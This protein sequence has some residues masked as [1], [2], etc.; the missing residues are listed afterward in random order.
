MSLHVS[1][2]LLEKYRTSAPRYT[3]YPTAID[4][5]PESFEPANYADELKAAA[6]N[7]APISVYVHVPFCEQMCLFC[8]CNVVITRSTDRVDRYLDRLECEFE[9]VG[10]TGIGSRPVHQ[11]HWGGGTPTHLTP[12]RML[13]LQ[14]AFDDVFTRTEDSESAIEV[15]PRV[16]TLEHLDALAQ[17]GFGRISMGV[18]DFEEDVQVAINRVQSIEQTRMLVDGAR[19]RGMQSVNIDLMYGLPHQTLEGFQRTI[20]VVL[21]MRPERVALFHYA[22]VPWMKKHQ[23]AL[24]MGVAPSSEIKLE[25]FLRAME[26]F[27]QAGY[28]Y[29]GLDHFA[30]PDDELARAAKAERLHRNF[31]GYTTHKG[32][33]MVS[34]GVSAIG[35]VNGCFAQ[36]F[37]SDAEYLDAID[38][39]GLATKRGHRMSDDDRLRRDI[40]MGIMCNGVLDT[41][42]IGADH[43]V[44]VNTMFAD[45]LK[46]LEPMVQDGLITMDANAV[47]LTE[48]GQLFMRNVALP[49]DRYFAARAAG[50]RDGDGTFSKT[51]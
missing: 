49:F 17:M 12:D 14:S 2:A 36:N 21:D 25:I 43:G 11:Y 34:L 46:S 8:G 32:S 28:V 38:D 30:L 1:A 3:S 48:L 19:A 20:D 44:D 6:N 26:A 15:D 51:L 42:R 13:R 41:Q 7:T 5:V 40:I 29:L 4:W 10:D 23:T 47:R 22:H 50:G 45:E 9:R 37:A 39:G 35:E 16:T 27:T 18:Q 33:E 31:M 24:D